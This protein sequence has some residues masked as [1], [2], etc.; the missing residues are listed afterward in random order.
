MGVLQ[1]SDGDSAAPELNRPSTGAMVAHP[2]KRRRSPIRRWRWGCIAEKV[3]Q[4][5]GYK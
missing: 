2:R 3:Y 1:V 5:R 4:R